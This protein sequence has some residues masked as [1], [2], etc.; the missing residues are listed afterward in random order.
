MVGWCVV[1]AAFVDLKASGN[2]RKGAKVVARGGLQLPA[3]LPACLSLQWSLL[4]CALLRSTAE[5]RG[6]DEI[7]AWEGGQLVQIQPRAV[8]VVVVAWNKKKGL[9]S[10]YTR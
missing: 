6:G 8:K 4:P 3:C 2:C 7:A 1:V 10:F 9:A 5:T